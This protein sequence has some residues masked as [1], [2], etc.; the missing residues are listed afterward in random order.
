MYPSYP[1]ENH[2]LKKQESN[3]KYAKI[4]Y[5]KTFTEPRTFGERFCGFRAY[6]IDDNV[7]M[8]VGWF[9]P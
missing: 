7:V 5:F 3:N 6:D 1:M 4:K 9:D 2:E 8:N